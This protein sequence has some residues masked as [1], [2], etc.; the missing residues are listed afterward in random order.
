[1][2]SRNPN[3]AKG[4]DVSHHQGN[5]AWPKV[6]SS[7]K[8]DFALIKAT[9]GLGYVDPK[10]SQN[11]KAANGVKIPVGFYHY[12][13]PEKNKALDEARMFVNATKGYQAQLPYVLDLEGSEAAAIDRAILSLW[14]Y[15]FMKEVQRLTGANVMLYTG[16]Y[17][18]RDQLNNILSEFPLWI[19]HYGSETPLTNDTWKDWTFFQYTSSGSIPGII[20]NVDLN[21]Y[22]GSVTEMFGYKMTPKDANKV[23]GFLKASYNSTDD[24]EAQAEY[25][26][27]ANELRKASGQPME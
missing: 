19:A 12:A 5:I 22:N 24:K 16:A 11:T 9:E 10:F 4:I 18:A 26:R 21:E 8:V 25:R 3:N 15:T 13:H 17:F 20:G 2:Q 23:I 27:L 6:A 14:A 7:G 1:M